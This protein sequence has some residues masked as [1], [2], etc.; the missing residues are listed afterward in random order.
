MLP[1]SP[2]T[3]PDVPDFSIRFFSGELRGG[4]RVYVATGQSLVEVRVPRQVGYPL[5]FR[6][7]VCGVH[8]SSCVSCQW[9]S[10]RDAPLPSFGARRARFP[11]LA[12]TMRALR[13]P[14]RV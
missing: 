14:I 9:L 10:P 12:S 13:L 11:A 7:Q 2:P 1:P 8:V 3:D 6:G 5:A 4:W